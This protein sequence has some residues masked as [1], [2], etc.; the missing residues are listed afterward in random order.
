MKCKKYME[1]LDLLPIGINE[2][3]K[4]EGKCSHKHSHSFGNV[5]LHFTEIISGYE[6]DSIL[7]ILIT[8]QGIRDATN[9][10]NV[11]EMFVAWINEKR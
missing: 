8:H 6:F 7:N 3:F 2:P 1:A 11:L 4:L 5:F 9:Y 10:F